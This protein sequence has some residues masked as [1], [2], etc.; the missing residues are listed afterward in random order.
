MQVFFLRELSGTPILLCVSLF[1]EKPKI[2]KAGHRARYTGPSYIEYVK[3]KLFE[4]QR[5]EGREE[6]IELFVDWVYN[7]Q[8]KPCLRQLY[9]FRL[10]TIRFMPSFIS[11]TFQF[12]RKP[13]FRFD[14]LR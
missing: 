8:K 1:F 9:S 2:L 4:P 12:R 14:S 11:A 13:R 7:Q 3:D 6:F 10:F 5:R